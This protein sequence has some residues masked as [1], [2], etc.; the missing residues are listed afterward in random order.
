M[1]GQGMLVYGQ[2]G[3]FNS[4]SEKISVYFEWLKL[5]IKANSV[6]QD[7]RVSV[8]LTVIGAND[9]ALLQGLVA[10]ESPWEKSFDELIKALNYEPKL[11]IIVERSCFYKHTQL[12]GE[13]IATFVADLRWLCYQLQFWKFCGQWALRVI[14]LW[15]AKRKT[16][17]KLLSEKDLSLA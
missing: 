3:E 6:M 17:R 2:L 14:G 9:Y 4:D 5:F 12:L 11:V 16:Q 10:P 8:L 15:V 1:S 7:K 13:M